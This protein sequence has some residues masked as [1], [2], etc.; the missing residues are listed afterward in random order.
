MGIAASKKPL[1]EAPAP[2]EVVAKPTLPPGGF[3]RRPLP[4]PAIAFSS[5]E[6]KSLLKKALAEGNA[7]AFFPLAEVM[8]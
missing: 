7:E 5:E 4:P 2:Q 1:G 8:K 3:H 6:G